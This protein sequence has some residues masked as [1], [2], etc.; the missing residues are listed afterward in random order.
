MVVQWEELESGKGVVALGNPDTSQREGGE[1]GQAWEERE[2]ERERERGGGVDKCTPSQ[3]TWALLPDEER[4]KVGRE[5]GRGIRGC[6]DIEHRYTKTQRCRHIGT[7]RQRDRDTW[8]LIQGHKDTE[9]EIQG[10]SDT[11]TDRH[12]DTGA[13]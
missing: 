1:E 10:H 12:R 8:P 5:G 6:K 7:Q 3:P 4:E 9:T 2:R 13:Q 11:G